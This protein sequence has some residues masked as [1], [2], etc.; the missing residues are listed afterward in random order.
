MWLLSFVWLLLTD[1]PYNGT[2]PSYGYDLEPSEEHQPHHDA[3]S[4]T[5]SPSSSPRLRS[6]SR[7]SR[8]TQSSGSLESTLSVMLLG[9]P[10]TN[11][12]DTLTV[13]LS[14][15]YCCCL[16]CLLHC[17]SLSSFQSL[18]NTFSSFSFHAE[19]DYF[20][21]LSVSVVCKLSLIF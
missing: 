18:S 7:S 13:S 12:P 20:Y 9:Q 11:M 1:A 6:K 5:G 4:Y 2:H 10:P 16:S 15:Q 14:S 8:D 3:L 19:N 21:C 17:P